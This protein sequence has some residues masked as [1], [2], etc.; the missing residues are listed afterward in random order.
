MS[1]IVSQRRNE[2]GTTKAT[3]ERK[4]KTAGNEMIQASLSHLLRGLLFVSR[5]TWK[6]Y[7][8]MIRPVMTDP[9]M[10]IAVPKSPNAV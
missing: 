10:T 7:T 4:E 8:A 9:A 2:L 1:L 3:S 6:T 5:Y